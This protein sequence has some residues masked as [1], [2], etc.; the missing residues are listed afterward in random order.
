MLGQAGRICCCEGWLAYIP[1]V[2]VRLRQ[3]CESQCVALSQGLAFCWVSIHL[4]QSDL[5]LRQAGWMFHPAG[6]QLGDKWHWKEPMHYAA[7][8]PYQ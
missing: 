1:A 3:A 8:M 2:G 6:A 5:M 4:C 7:V